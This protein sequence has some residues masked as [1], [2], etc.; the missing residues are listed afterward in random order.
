MGQM[1]RGYVVRLRRHRRHR[2]IFVHEDNFLCNRRSIQG[3]LNIWQQDKMSSKTRLPIFGSKTRR[4]TKAEAD[5]PARQD[6][7]Q[8]EYLA[9]RQDVKQIQRHVALV[10]KRIVYSSYLTI[11]PEFSTL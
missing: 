1:L 4:E 10:L 6:V 7:K 3:I 11:Y 2:K 9:A 5:S 8:I